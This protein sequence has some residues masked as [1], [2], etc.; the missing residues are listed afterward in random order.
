VRIL[1]F[2]HSF[3]KFRKMDKGRKGPSKEAPERPL[4]R[5]FRGTAENAKTRICLRFVKMSPR[6]CSLLS[7][8]AG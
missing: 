4:R 5:G 1:A 7:F 6:L 2:A 8:I 3:S